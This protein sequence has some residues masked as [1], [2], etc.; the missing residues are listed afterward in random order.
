V[1]NQ[2]QHQY[3]RDQPCEEQHMV[4]RLAAVETIVA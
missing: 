3:E 1:Q 4:Y 2:T